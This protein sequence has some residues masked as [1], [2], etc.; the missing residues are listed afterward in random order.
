MVPKARMLSDFL[1]KAEGPLTA[2]FQREYGLRLKDA[3]VDR[4]EDEVL[5]LITWLPVSSAFMATLQSNGD[6]NKARGLY[7]WSATE[8]LLLGIANRVSHQ[9][10]VVAQTQSTK[11]LSAPEPVPGPRGKTPNGPKGGNATGMARALLA[12]QKGG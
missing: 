10:Y 5:D 1:T 8:D 11:K 6:K 2:D 3:V 7:S 4:D 9:T 12:A